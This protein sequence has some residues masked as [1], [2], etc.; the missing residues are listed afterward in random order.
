MWSSPRLVA[1]TIAATIAS[2]IHYIKHFY[3]LIFISAKV[4][5]VNTGWD[6]VLAH[7]VRRSFCVY[8]DS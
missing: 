5:V 6:T 2:C 8:D 4:N 1:V 3:F 7:S